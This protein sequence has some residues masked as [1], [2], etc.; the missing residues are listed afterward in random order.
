MQETKTTFNFSI[1]VLDMS[2]PN[3]RLECFY[4][5]CDIGTAYEDDLGMQGYCKVS[6]I[7]EREALDN[8]LRGFDVR[9]ADRGFKLTLDDID[10]GQHI[11]DVVIS[12]RH[13]SHY[14]PGIVE[15]RVERVCIERDE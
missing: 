12:A 6:G 11:G 13:L 3:D 2:A 4:V 5:T 15:A 8:L 1:D 14:S 7:P 10:D 9:P